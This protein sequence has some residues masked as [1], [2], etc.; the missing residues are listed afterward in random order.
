MGEE[1]TRSYSTANGIPPFHTRNQ[2]LKKRS[3]HYNTT[4]THYETFNIVEDHAQPTLKNFPRLNL[5]FNPPVQ[6]IFNLL[7]FVPFSFTVLKIQRHSAK[8]SNQGF[9]DTRNQTG[10]SEI[11]SSTAHSQILLTLIL[12]MAVPRVPLPHPPSAK[13][14]TA[15]LLS[16]IHTNRH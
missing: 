11:N 2:I 1:A 14:V 4:R 9:T 13:S 10:N 3:A 6:F 7:S 16:V 8:L 15:R 12:G 5:L